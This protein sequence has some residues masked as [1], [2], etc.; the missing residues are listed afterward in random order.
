MYHL[1][2]RW[3]GEGVATQKGRI[4]FKNERIKLKEIPSIGWCHEHLVKYLIARH[5]FIFWFGSCLSTGCWIIFFL[6]S[7][8]LNSSMSKIIRH[9]ITGYLADDLHWFDS[10]RF[11]RINGWCFNLS[12]FSDQTLCYSFSLSHLE[13]GWFEYP[14]CDNYKLNI[15]STSKN[16]VC[17]HHWSLVQQFYW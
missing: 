3:Q 9:L 1:D 12:I 8:R 14:N 5:S 16:S 7:I 13:G 15:L 17:N 6:A 4:P 10:I 11:I 2:F